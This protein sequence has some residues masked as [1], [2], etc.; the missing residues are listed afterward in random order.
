MLVILSDM[1]TLCPE[2]A[3]VVVLGTVVLL[4]LAGLWSAYLVTCV[5]EARRRT[6]ARRVDA[7]PRAHESASTTIRGVL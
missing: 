6:I 2:I 3:I 1:W 4:A 7:C 5:Q